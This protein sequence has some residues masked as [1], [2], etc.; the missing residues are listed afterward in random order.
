MKILKNRIFY[1]I[2]F[3]L[4]LLISI[5]V[6]PIKVYAANGTVSF[7]SEAYEKADGEEFPVGIYVRGETDVTEYRVE[8]K[9]DSARLKYVS[10]AEEVNEEEGILTF[11]GNANGENEAK[12]WLTLKA[13]SG[14]EAYLEV[15]K[16][17]AKNSLGEDYEITLP[18]SVKIILSGEDRVAAEQALKEAAEQASQ[19]IEDTTETSVSDN[20]DMDADD[21]ATEDII[22][23]EE[24]EQDEEITDD[25][26]ES[27]I[28]TET[29]TDNNALV[30]QKTVSNSFFSNKK[31]VI[32]CAVAAVG[33]IVIAVTAIIFIIRGRKKNESIDLNSAY[34]PENLSETRKG[35]VYNE[36]DDIEMIDFG[37]SEYDIPL[38]ETS[39]NKFDTND[40]DDDIRTILFTG[41]EAELTEED[42][43]ENIEE[44]KNEVSENKNVR[45]KARKKEN[46]EETKDTKEPVIRV[47]DVT[48]KFRLSNS[49]ASGFKEYLIQKIQHQVVHK[50]LLALN[51]VSFD[52]YKGE[53][54]GIIGTNGSGKSTL[55]KIVSGALNPTSGKVEVDRRK[56]Q[57]LSLGAGFDMELTARENVYLNGSIIGYSKEFI[58]AN[59]NKIVEFAELDGFMDQR[60][61]NFSSGMVSR[62]GFAI[63]TAGN[64]SEILILDEVLSVGDEFFRKKSLKRVKEMIHSGSTVIMVSHSMNSILDNCTRVVWIE[65]GVLKMIGRPK[66]VCKAYSMRHEGRRE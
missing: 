44:E 51:H 6:I 63:A 34:S 7:G 22:Q 19:E 1:N 8:L 60:V 50:D 12:L 42:L 58:D 27:D 39:K 43:P 61:K 55:L 56:I 28:L 4:I 40:E 65:K 57:L 10:G 31:T 20:N 21:S 49:N 35:Y 18:G 24:V 36:S 2:I 23:S 38:V 26:E 25:E 29:E 9:Y 32:I 53:V 11:F 3:C 66:M 5:L 13:Q 46:K 33:I 45:K 62:L 16:A 47:D 54:I 41:N 52:I 64:V 30:N 59:Y 14:G 15:V 48:M 37:S 17:S